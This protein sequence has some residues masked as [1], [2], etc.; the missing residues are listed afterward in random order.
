MAVEDFAGGQVGCDHESMDPPVQS[1]MASAASSSAFS[2]SFVSS[3][4]SF[5][6]M[7]SCATQRT[8]LTPSTPR[9]VSTALRQTANSVR[10]MSTSPHA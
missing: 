6:S 1:P 9:R 5:R 7:S 10:G 3:A 4:L 2:F 8:Q